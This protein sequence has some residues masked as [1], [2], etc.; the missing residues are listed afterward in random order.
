MALIRPG[1]LVGQISGRL[2]GDVF[3][4]N[5][6]GQYVRS[7]TN[8]VTSTTPYALAAK[9]RM[10]TTSQGWQSLS[11]AL[12]LAWNAWASTNP[13]INRLGESIHLTGHAAYVSINTRLL[14]CAVAGITAP[15]IEPAPA[16]LLTLTLAAD[17]GPGDFEFAYTAT[18][19]AAAD[20]LWINACVLDSTGINYVANYLRLVGV[21]AA[22]QA[23]PF[24]PQ[25]LIEARFG[26]V[27]VDQ[28][29]VATV[30]VFDSLTGQLS[31]PL[32][33]QATVVDTTV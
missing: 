14:A 23:S 2:G 26:S 18:P 20:Y 24:D 30:S 33:C 25:T 17:I 8:P 28:I 5:R 11:A 32:R 4:H 12:K 29:I 13:T 10:T 3:S 6:Y 21:S 1:G 22:E 7:G 19:L 16:P 15:P 27:A 31:A 9:A